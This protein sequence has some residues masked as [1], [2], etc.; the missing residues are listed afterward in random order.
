MQESIDKYK[1]VFTTIYGIDLCQLICVMKRDYTNV[2]LDYK[3]NSGQYIR[4]RN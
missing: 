1:D 3:R 2:V 4:Q